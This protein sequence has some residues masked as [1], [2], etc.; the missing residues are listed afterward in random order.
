MK[1]L[2]VLSPF[3]LPAP[4]GAGR[5]YSLL[6][7]EL[8]RTDTFKKISVYTE[9]YPG[10]LKLE[11]VGS[12][13]VT[14]NRVF[15][16]RAGSNKLSRAKYLKYLVQN[17][18]IVFLFFKIFKGEK[19]FL[20]HGYFFN[21]IS[22]VG[23]L[24]RLLRLN[25]FLK[26]KVIAD[27]RDPKLNAKKISRLNCVD[28][29]I[30]CS[31]NVKH[32]L[33]DNGWH[34]Q[35]INHIPVPFEPSIPQDSKVQS[36]LDKFSLL[37]QRYVFTPNGISK[38]KSIDQI[39]ELTKALKADGIVDKLVVAGRKRDSDAIIE[40]AINDGILVY[41]GSLPHEQ[42]LCLT[43]S[44]AIVPIISLKVEG[45]PRT[46]L[47]ALVMNVPVL[48]PDNV[49]E[50]E[51]FDDVCASINDAESS[52]INKAKDIIDGGAHYPNYDLSI[53]AWSSLTPKYLSLFKLIA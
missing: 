48:L 30:V 52:L 4:G 11:K 1:E 49:P 41:V 47:E 21:N 28:E 38:E 15:P 25:P 44:A 3:Y 50:F 27:L 24:I 18:Q 22:S 9:K 33:L 2:A 6:V 37:K 23:L 31:L 8:S 14:I 29:I 13:N 26:V 36:L 17:L 42:I 35:N 32:H 20:V 46:A 34:K 53:H 39:L 51:R 16:F 43:H 19:I 40:K 5:Y 45:M 12:S 10:Q 7:K